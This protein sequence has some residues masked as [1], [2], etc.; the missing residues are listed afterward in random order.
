VIVLTAASADANIVASRRTGVAESTGNGVRVSGNPRFLCCAM[1]QS[2]V[3]QGV[4]PVALRAQ[5]P[6]VPDGTAGQ[7]VGSAVI[8]VRPWRTCRSPKGCR[9]FSGSEENF[10]PG[11]LVRRT[12]RASLHVPLTTVT[13]EYPPKDP[14]S[15]VP[16]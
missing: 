9:G 5:N 7:S 10:Q 13:C 11:G 3:M 4:P 2:R 12:C 1:R 6:R 15:N 8:T 16:Q 14:K